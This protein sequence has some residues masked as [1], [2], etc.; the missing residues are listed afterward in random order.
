[1]LEK[2]KG[3]FTLTIIKPGAIAHEYI[4]PIL[5]IIN[6]HGFHVAALK[7]IKLTR[8]QAEFFYEIHR[9]KPFFDELVDFMISGPIVAA[10]LEKTNAVSDFRQLIGATDPKKA[11]KGTIRRLFAESLEKNAIHGSDSDDN[12]VKEAD[13]FFARSERFFLK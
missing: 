5:H 12:A 8:E 3:T 4:G 1:M 10:I 13:F 6:E 2:K 11:R 7:F 9:D